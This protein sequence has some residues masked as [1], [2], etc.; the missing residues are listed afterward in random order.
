VKS[1]IEDQFRAVKRSHKRFFINQEG[2]D[3][4][5]RDDLE[6]VQWRC[7]RDAE[8]GYFYEQPRRVR[9]LAVSTDQ[10]HQQ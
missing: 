3:W 5:E 4:S 2:L 10:E 6:T 1:V 8:Q 9:T 7:N